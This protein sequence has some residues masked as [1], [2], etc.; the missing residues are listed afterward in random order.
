[1]GK[2]V[3]SRASTIIM[4]LL[5]SLVWSCSS[6][7][8]LEEVK[9]DFTY[10]EILGKWETTSYFCSD[11]YF[12]QI[13]IDEWFQFNKDKTYIYNNC[14]DQDH[15]TFRYDKKSKLIDCKDSRG[16]DMMIRVT[17]RDENKAVFDVIGK[18]EVQNMKIKVERKQTPK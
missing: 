16:W 1:M 18:T 3:I 12:V 13:D 5:A 10:S 14:G 6:S 4:V 2:S 15:G 17:F 7:D 9:D 8:D 11:G